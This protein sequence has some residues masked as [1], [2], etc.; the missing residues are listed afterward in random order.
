MNVS[1]IGAN[2]LYG[3]V[4]GYGHK[5]ADQISKEVAAK[6]EELDADGDRALSAEESD[7][8]TKHFSQADSDGDGFLSE[9]ELLAMMQSFQ[10]G[11][12][13]PGVSIEE[14]AVNI[15]AENDADADGALSVE[16]VDG[17]KG[18]FSAA[19]AD[20]DGLVTKEELLA[21]M[22]S[23]QPGGPPPGVSTEEMAANIIAEND[24][25]GDGALSLAE[26]EGYEGQFS[27][28]DADGDGLVTKEELAAMIEAEWPMGPP[29]PE[30]DAAR[31]IAKYDADG[32]G[33]ISAS[34]SGVP[35]EVFDAIDTN[36]DGVISQAELEAALTTMQQALEDSGLGRGPE[37]IEAAG[38][39]EA[40]HE[41]MYR[42]ILEALTSG[43]TQP[44]DTDGGEPSPIGPHPVEPDKGEPVPIGPHPVGPDNGEPVPIGPYPVGPDNGEPVPIGPHPVGPDNDTTVE[45]TIGP[46]PVEPDN[47]EPVPVG[48]YP[49]G[50]DEGEAGFV[51]VTV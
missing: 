28:A 47:G 35:D 31:R 30:E 29:P 19:D 23:F 15:I 25:D 34:E 17:Q 10:P 12:P 8:S 14:M 24:A 50:P 38:G 44:G 3:Y 1:G 49:V 41:E 36:E 16:E 45:N 21:M 43:D 40:Y 32:D 51:S 39:I 42:I 4:G 6:I 20:G 7:F 13:P 9:G 27:A 18:R 48:P 11:L 37:A 2:F 22:Q 5:S 46:N 26:S 33:V